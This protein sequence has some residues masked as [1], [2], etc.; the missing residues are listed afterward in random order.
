MHKKV[1]VLPG[2][3]IGPEVM[4][5]A[6]A[7]L[8]KV[9]QEFDH[10]FEVREGLVGGAAYDVTGDALPQE[11]ISLAEESDAILFGSVG[12]PKWEH[13]PRNAQP[14]RRA[15]L[16]L[17]SHFGLYANLRP[18]RVYPEL[19]SQSALR[20]ESVA[21][22]FDLLIVR[23]LTGG[24]Y[25]GK[26]RE[27]T[28]QG[29]EKVALDTMRYR[30]DEI[31][32]IAHVAFQAAQKRRKSLVSVDKANV[33]DCSVLWREVVEQVAKDYSDVKLS[34]LY[35]DNAAM[36][37][38]LKPNQFDVLLTGNL[39]GDILSDISSV[40][41]GSLGMIP[42]ASLNQ[43]AFG[44]YEPAG[45]SAPDI[46][47][48]GVANPIAQILSVALM[49]QHSFGLLEEARA[50]E[51]SVENVLQQGLRTGDIFQDGYRQV[52][53]KEMGQAIVENIHP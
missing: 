32:R 29:K 2:D 50:V 13:L 47:G 23:E 34:H 10:T 18:S 53:T 25:F 42:S 5:Q 22:G 35:V 43:S 12:G 51:K 45:G 31:E 39:F 11:T 46:A 9:G 19:A 20:H 28:G 7:V 6:T 40:L 41:P 24:I 33:L 21:L 3:G 15:L 38:I 37:L 48:Q 30:Y 44:L 8:E 14:E 49:L 16:T 26:P 4:A 17:R 1:A 52:G 27:T 36:Q